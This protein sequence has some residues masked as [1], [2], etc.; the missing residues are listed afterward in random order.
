MCATRGFRKI[1]KVLIPF[2]LSFITESFCTGGDFQHD[3]KKMF[4]L[5]QSPL[6]NGFRDKNSAK[7]CNED[8]TSLK[9]AY[10]TGFLK[11]TT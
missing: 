8:G 1:L 10:D 11:K 5:S 3:Y 2:S 4:V 9:I 7:N 6:I